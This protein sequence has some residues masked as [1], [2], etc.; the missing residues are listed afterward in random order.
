[1]TVLTMVKKANPTGLEKTRALGR[2]TSNHEAE[3][4]SRGNG[5]RA[6]RLGS[7]EKAGFLFLCVS[8]LAQR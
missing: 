5:E 3:G 4:I 6:H 8:T 1:M 7:K 2:H